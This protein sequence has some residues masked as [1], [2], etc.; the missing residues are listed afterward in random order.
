MLLANGINQEGQAPGNA[1]VV[2]EPSPPGASAAPPTAPEAKKLV[3][4][5]LEADDAEAFRTIRD[6]VK[7]QEMLARNRFALDKHFTAAKMGYSGS[8]L[9]KAEN[10]DSYTQAWLPGTANRLQSAD[11]PNKQAEL[12]QRLT[13]TLLVDPPK[14]EPEAEDDDETAQRGAEL[15]REYLQQDG[16]EAGTDDLTLYAELIEGATT[17]AS[18]FSYYWID[19]EGGGS[20]PKQI[21]AHPQAL[22]ATRPLEAFAVDPATG[23]EVAVPTTDYILRYV[24]PD[25]QFTP[26]PSEAERVWLP[27]VRIEKLGREHVRL[28]PETA[29]L[30]H[31][32]QAIVLHYCT[33]AEG[34]RR[35]PETLGAMDDAALTPVVGWTPDRPLA[36]LPPMLRAKWR[37]G[38]TEAS[39]GAGTKLTAVDQ[40]LMFYYAYHGL[41]DSTY[42]EGAVV[43]VNG[44][45]GGLVLGRDTLTA[46]VEIPSEVTQDET[47]TDTKDLDLPLAQ[48]RLLAD[49]DERDPMGTAF[50][51]RI[52]GGGAAM[53]FMASSMQEAIDI[54]L[55]PVRYSIGTSS[56]EAEDV[57]EARSTGRFVH[58]NTTDEVPKLEERRDLPAAYFNQVAWLGDQLDASAG[59]RP[60]DKATEA[61]VKS[62]VALRI[63][64]Q[65]ATKT[66]TRMNYAFHAF[67][68]R[69]GRIKLQMA[70][71]HFGVPQLLRYVGTD[72]AAKQE[73]FT[74]NDFA[75]VGSVTIATGSGTMLPWS[76]KVNLALQL[77]GAGMMDPDEANDIARPAFSKQLGAAENPH[78]QRIERQVS[79]WLEGPPEGW[80]AKAAQYGRA[81]AL[82]AEMTQAML[83]ENPQAEIPPTPDAP[84]TPFDIEVMDAEPPIAAIRKR[85]L[86]R[87]MAKTEFSKFGEPWKQLVR[88]A[89]TQAAQVITAATMA[90]QPVAGPESPEAGADTPDDGSAA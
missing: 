58:V 69:H 49:T 23:Q 61:K 59:L 7:R 63:E 79:S 60:P 46:T 53:S 68:A 90:A 75:R 74:G 84:W 12:C 6:L 3:G 86:S 11:V 25:N 22:D 17:R 57:E 20:M 26:N 83:A 48:L 41:A 65:E 82:H 40:R 45:N 30:H 44:A 4:P 47:V 77:Q 81:V 24:T 51:R 19:P 10:Q 2:S 15:A 8:F 66:L 52:A 18:T 32:Q 34:K 76:E 56:A 72:G 16:T 28:Y 38:W 21:K 73:W 29:D 35:W 62:G 33:V 1:G 71:K 89:Y 55:H 13:E 50:M 14:L 36:L 80:E 43:C 88:D 85:R 5:L 54:V 9:V 78:V 67:A 31:A 37:E 87:L 64:V 70:M 27:R 42:P 39:A